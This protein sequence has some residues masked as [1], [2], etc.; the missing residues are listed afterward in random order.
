MHTGDSV[1]FNPTQDRL[2]LTARFCCCMQCAY[3]CIYDPVSF[4][5]V[6]SRAF[7]TS[8][9]IQ[10]RPVTDGGFIG[11]HGI[12]PSFLLIVTILPI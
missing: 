1:A 4:L 12:A 11:K 5:C 8:Q 6:C 2:C 3:K 7:S 10:L 9:L